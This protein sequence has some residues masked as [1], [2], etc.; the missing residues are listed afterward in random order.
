LLPINEPTTGTRRKSQIQSYLEHHRG[1]GIQHIA[2]FT[3]DIIAT[4]KKMELAA[5]NGGG[6]SFMPHPGK[7]YY[8]EHVPRKM[9]G[10]AEVNAALIAECDKRAILIDRD[11]EGT[12]LQVF[13]Q[14]IL[15][16]PTL[17]IE[18][19]QRLGC[20]LPN[21]KQKPGCGGF[22]K[23]NFGA[24]FKSIETMEKIRDGEL[25]AGAA[26]M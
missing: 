24:L 25:P 5:I 6:I 21:G 12:L 19:I 4:A 10:V 20:P 22:G 13:T 7:S 11:Q 14:T 8:T 18:V 26:G 9:E 16:R 17:F 2:I 23:N 1:P 3:S 15:D